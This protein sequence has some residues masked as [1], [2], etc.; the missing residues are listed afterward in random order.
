MQ[1]EVNKKICAII[2]ELN[3]PHN[4]HKYLIDKARE[5]SGCDY[6]LLIMSPNYVQRGEPAI[7]DCYTRAEMALALGAD[8]VVFM[9]TEYAT[10]S[11]E[12]FCRAGVEIAGG[13]RNVSHL[14]FGIDGAPAQLLALATLIKNNSKTIDSLIVERLKSGES[15]SKAK[16]DA[17]TQIGKLSGIDSYY[18]S[19]PNNILALEYLIN[20]P[21]FI[22]PILVQRVGG[23]HIASASEIRNT[24]VEIK[25]Q[26]GN[27]DDVLKYVP[28]QIHDQYIE[29]EIVDYEKF[30]NYVMGAIS[31]STREE[32][33]KFRDV[34][35]GMENLFISKINGK[36]N[37][38][39]FLGAIKS[40][41]YSIKRLNRACLAIALKI[42][43][44]KDIKIDRLKLAGAS[45][46]ALKYLDCKIPLIT[47][48]SGL[49]DIVDTLDERSTRLYN[50]FFKNNKKNS[51]WLKKFIKK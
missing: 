19:S 25:S 3:P 18:L 30:Q 14:A 48:S 44:S 4:G 38:L 22:T 33:A 11:A 51:F 45:T 27:I 29:A 5:L 47:R 23:E 41:R 24:L 26:D 50:N 7:F 34:G 13:F 31:I 15:Y 16:S 39:D 35:E 28:T 49:E 6:I 36:K 37:Y 40:K 43:P 9:P 1:N 10:A 46:T 12:I 42:Y 20:L 17:I 21:Q 32:L 2:C 8:A